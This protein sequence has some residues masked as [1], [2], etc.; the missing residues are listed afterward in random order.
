MESFVHDVAMANKS[1]SSALWYAPLRGV[2]SKGVMADRPGSLGGLAAAR[3][4][5]Q[6][7]FFTPDAVAKVM[8]LIVER[9]MEKTTYKSY[10][11]I[12]DNSVGS[13]RL[14]QYANPEKHFLAGVDVDQ[15]LLADVG[16]VVEEAGFKC[17][18][19]PCGMEGIHPMGFDFA[20]IN[21]PFSVHIN[22][23]LLQPYRCT[24]YGKFGPNTATLSHAYAL[25]Q[26]LEAAEIVVALLP[27]SFVEEVL[28]NPDDYLGMEDAKRLAMVI[29][30]PPN[31]FQ[32][33][34]TAVSTSLLVFTLHHAK[35]KQDE[36]EVP[37]IELKS[38]DDPIPDSK[39]FR[40]MGYRSNPRLN[41]QGIEDEGPSITLPVTGD[42]LVRVTH[43]QRHIKLQFN[44]GLTQAK[45]QNA[46]LRSHVKTESPPLHRHPKGIRYCGQGALDVEVHLAQDDPLRSFEKF[47]E[48]IKSAGG[49]P[50]VDKG[51]EGYVRRRARQSQRQATPLRHTV[52][53]E[54]GVAAGDASS[55]VAEPRNV[56]A[57]DPT[58]WGSPILRP[59]QSV[60]FERD[61]NGNYTGSVDG[62]AFSVSEQT[63]YEK[64]VVTKGA[65][66]SGWTVVHPGLH[67]AFPELSCAVKR[68]AM[69]LGID[70]W[71]N[72]QYQFDDVTELAMKPQG[73]IPAWHM[74]LG[75]ARLA[76]ALI[77]LVGCRRGLIVTEAG[78]VDEMVTELK[79]LP[80]PAES[81]QVIT[82]PS[83]AVNLRQINVISYER[84]RLVAPV[85]SGEAP[86]K[87]G[88]KKR[89]HHTY[90]GLMRRRIGVLVAD[91]GD[92]L[93]NPTSDQSQALF[94][95]SA[96]RRYVMTGTP[97]ANYPRDT[98]PILAFA[99]G[100]GTAA[101]PWGWHKGRLE[102]NWIASVSHAER[103][104]DAFRNTFVTMEWATREFEDTLIEGAKRE[105]PRINNISGYREM[106]A[107]HIKRRISD[108]PDVARYIQIPK[109]T[110]EIVTVEW[111]EAHL[112]FYIQVADEFAHWYT[113]QRRADGKNSNLIAILARLRAVSFASDYP[114][115][116]VEGFGAYLPL[117]S[118]QRWA[119]DELE[120]LAKEGKKTML[121]VDNP[122]QVELLHRHLANRGVDS[123][124]FHGQIPI[125]KRTAELNQRF[126]FGDC[127]IALATLGVV[128]KG[129]N[130]WQIEEEI[131]LNRSWSASVEEQAI[132]RALR[133]QQKKNVRVRYAHL[134]GGIDIYKDQL[135]SFKRDTMKVGVDWATPET[136][137]LEFLHFDTVLGR[138][139]EDVAKMHNIHRMDL[140]KYLRTIATNAKEVSYA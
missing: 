2:V 81:W 79:G 32:E 106:L 21:P 103:G 36:T 34:G 40:L 96:K 105:I 51:L 73:A 91:E 15:S 20:L 27:R 83:Q 133:P 71:M 58:V 86:R 77:L 93:S 7:Q 67:E 76:V 62:Y 112:A 64:F 120:Q 85:E 37:R 84:L 108:E 107:P 88:V 104:L 118:K 111:D 45:V 92:L 135:V 90:A 44:C 38:I 87:I 42:T 75:K 29:D 129:L 137:E 115:H 121:Y 124:R 39:K 119:L 33:E 46:I 47:V 30:L 22:S 28:S 54:D 55:V 82:K 31:S 116:G 25:S 78:L 48:A 1:Q 59:G 18:F 17:N 125:K 16:K 23:P 5:H 80:I 114:Q 89:M 10:F 53:M 132:W 97:I 138:F 110:R 130:L 117:T 12:L 60:A 131:F 100:D 122:G 3:R 24:T 8:W 94:Q 68:R 56:M 127:P 101:Q 139:A 4:V 126:R 109:E 13:G 65:T 98:A 26:A 9:M 72:W 102:K 52:W 50:L 74:G 11:N 43:D 63:L 70:R 113:N 49:E 95:L 136:E 19:E 66:T 99:C 134:P 57:A 41:L 128:Q 69:Q 14:F 140:K 35:E 6:G 61:A 123:V